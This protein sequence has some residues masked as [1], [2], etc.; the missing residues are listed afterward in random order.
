[1]E[2]EQGDV[3]WE[4]E[5]MLYAPRGDCDGDVYS[6]KPLKPERKGLTYAD[7]S[8]RDSVVQT[9]AAPPLEGRRR[10]IVSA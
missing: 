7:Q 8:G 2:R 3:R 1:M 9:G 5:D 4:I 10:A 6:D